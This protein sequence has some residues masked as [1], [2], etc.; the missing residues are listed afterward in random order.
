MSLMDMQ[1][2]FSSSAVLTPSRVP[3]KDRRNARTKLP[4]GLVN[5]QQDYQDVGLRVLIVDQ[6]AELLDLEVKQ[7]AQW[8]RN[9]QL[10]TD[11]FSALRMAARQHPHVVIIQLDLG[12]MSGPTLARHLRQDF[13]GGDALFIGLAKTEDEQLRQHSIA[14]GIDV[15]L[16]R[17]VC[18]KNIETLLILES[19]RLNGNP[20]KRR[21]H[22][23]RQPLRSS[24]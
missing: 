1:E 5:C 19:I 15:L 7:I 11:G 21:N 9:L 23:I 6:H 3:K 17:P 4:I 24:S 18:L 2:V 13:A 8:T 14:C 22:E 20:K 16:V 10:A 12:W